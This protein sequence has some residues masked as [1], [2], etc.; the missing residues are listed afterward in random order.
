MV[1]QLDKIMSKNL[2]SWGTSHGYSSTMKRYEWLN[3]VAKKASAGKPITADEFKSFFDGIADY[4]RNWFTTFFDA[5][6]KYEVSFI[7]PRFSAVESDTV[8]NSETTMW[9]LGAIYSARFLGRAADGTMN[10]S[11]LVFPEAEACR[12]RKK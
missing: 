1:W 2:G 6:L 11:P 10:P 4:P 3:Q 12:L 9:E 7:T 5:F 8:I